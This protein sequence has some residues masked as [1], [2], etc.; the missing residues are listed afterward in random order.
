MNICHLYKF[1]V[2]CTL[3]DTTPQVAWRCRPCI[4]NCFALVTVYLPT[5]EGHHC[6]VHGIRHTAELRIVHSVRLEYELL[7][8]SINGHLVHFF[9]KCFGSCCGSSSLCSLVH[10][11]CICSMSY[12][13]SF[14][15][16]RL[17]DAKLLRAPKGLSQ[18]LHSSSNPL[19]HT[20]ELT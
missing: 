11:G 10:G 12:S 9:Q 18:L 7:K 3:N 20:A 14:C 19:G 8:K 6:V 4:L 17:C 5:S 2:F 15:T 1:W 16:F 13:F